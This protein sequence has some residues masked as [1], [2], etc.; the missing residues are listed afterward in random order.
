MITKNLPSFRPPWRNFLRDDSRMLVEE[1][2]PHREGRGFQPG[3]SSE[4]REQRLDVGPNRRRRHS[5]AAYHRGGVLPGDKQFQALPLTGGEASGES[6]CVALA[7]QLRM[8]RRPCG[9]LYDDFAA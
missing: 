4:L 8:D 1:P 7:S 2:G 3:V 6:H 5:E 9:H